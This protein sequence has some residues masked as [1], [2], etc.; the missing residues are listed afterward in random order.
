MKSIS[1]ESTAAVKFDAFVYSN[2]VASSARNCIFTF[3]FLVRNCELQN[4]RV[5]HNQFTDMEY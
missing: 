2:K 3:W 5:K 4:C 1:S